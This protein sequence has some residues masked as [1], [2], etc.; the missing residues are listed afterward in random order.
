[1]R[2]HEKL[3]FLPRNKYHLTTFKA[4]LTDGFLRGAKVE[5]F[6]WLGEGKCYQS[7]RKCQIGYWSLRMNKQYGSKYHTTGSRFV[8]NGKLDH[9]SPHKMKWKET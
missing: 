2:F 8:Q 1:M 9:S 5:V 6:K 4:T 3:Y 7:Y